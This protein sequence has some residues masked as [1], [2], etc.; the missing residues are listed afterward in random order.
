MGINYGTAMLL[1]R[2]GVFQ[3][4]RE[5]SETCSL[6]M[7]GRQTMSLTNDNQKKAVINSFKNYGKGVDIRNKSILRDSYSEDFLT[8]VGVTSIDSLD[9]SEFENC[10]TIKNLNTLFSNDK[11]NDEIK[12]KYDIVLD[13]GTSEHVFSPPTSIANSIFMLKNGG[14]LVLVLPISGWIEHGFY[15]FS[16][17]F[18]RSLEVKGLI[19]KKLYIFNPYSEPLMIWDGIKFINITLYESMSGRFSSFA[20]YEKQEIF[21]Q[22]FFLTNVNQ[23]VYVNAWSKNKEATPQASIKKIDPIKWSKRIVEIVFG[24]TYFYKYLVLLKHRTD[25]DSVTKIS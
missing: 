22:D 9:C 17:N 12:E 15:Q 25:I 4:Y 24:Q 16:P 6:M 18:F 14:G 1:S 3:K 5:S 2:T 8:D 23:G 11:S 21:S 10:S 13:F 7:L 20:V 19:L